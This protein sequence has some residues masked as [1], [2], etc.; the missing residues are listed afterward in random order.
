MAKD[1]TS[2]VD[3]FIASAPESAQDRLVRLRALVLDNL[4]AGAEESINWG[5]PTYR[6]GGKIALNFTHAKN[7]IGLF[8]GADNIAALGGKLDS[9]T[10]SKAVIHLP[11]DR[12]LPE[13]IIKAAVKQAAIA[14]GVDSKP[15]ARP[16]ET[17][18]QFVSQEL[19][20]RGLEA[21]YDARP[22]YQR[23]DYL[24]WINTAKQDTTKQRR[25]EQMLAELESGDKYMGMDYNSKKRSSQ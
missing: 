1:K 8:V 5:M 12:P 6:V 9:F 11:N 15:A 14:P 2:T 7:H 13:T 21:A 3:E 10:T 18:P 4:P 19:K 22:P 24:S 16:R 20:A 25:L 17:M 23:N